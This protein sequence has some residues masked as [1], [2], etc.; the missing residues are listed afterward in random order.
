V[1]SAHRDAL[2]AIENSLALLSTPVDRF[3]RSE[4]TVQRTVALSRRE[5]AATARAAA[6]RERQRA[7]PSPAGQELFRRAKAL[8]AR[9]SATV[10]AFA[11]PEDNAA[12]ILPARPT[13]RQHP[14]A[15][16]R[17]A[18]PGSTRDW[19]GAAVCRMKAAAQHNYGAAGANPAQYAQDEPCY[20]QFVR[21]FLASMSCALTP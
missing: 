20:G 2:E 6:Q 16:R 10:A 12:L 21:V 11:V 13:H 15:T 1:I 3:Q 17:A 8:R 5:A 9:L 4:E 7:Y 14:A 18:E 19:P